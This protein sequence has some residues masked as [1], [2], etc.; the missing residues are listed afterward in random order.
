MSCVKTDTTCVRP[1]FDIE[2]AKIAI[3]GISLLSFM[4]GD[5]LVI[6]NSTPDM[7]LSDEPYLSLMLF[8]E[9]KSGTYI[10]RIWNRTVA[11][12]KTV[13]IEQLVDLC[14]KH[15]FQGRPCIG[16]PQDVNEEE[17]LDFVIS[18]TPIP[19]KVSKYCHEVLGSDATDEESACP[20]CLKIGE[21][22]DSILM[23]VGTKCEVVIKSEKEEW[24]DTN[25]VES[26]ISKSTDEDMRIDP[27]KIND[28]SWLQCAPQNLKM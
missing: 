14:K 7:M 18:Q 25:M 23:D 21:S 20:E 16:C 26:T 15:F 4:M 12:G 5:F 1:E 3:T 11:R 13:T 19:R 6:M 27:I 8:V 2:G 17:G 9:I 10:R 22:G 24:H 28:D